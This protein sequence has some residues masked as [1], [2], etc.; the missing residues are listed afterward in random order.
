MSPEE[1]H[2]ACQRR[3]KHAMEVCGKDASQA[4]LVG[5]L[6]GEVVRLRVALTAYV[7][8]DD[9]TKALE[10]QAMKALTD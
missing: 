10:A 6:A 4:Q 3:I 2:A 1:Y 7:N 5:H 9:W 8:A